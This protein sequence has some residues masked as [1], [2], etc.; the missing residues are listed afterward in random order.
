MAI[1]RLLDRPDP[2]AIERV[3]WLTRLR[4]IASHL[5]TTRRGSPSLDRAVHTSD[6]LVNDQD[7]D[8][9]LHDM[10]KI[11]WIILALWVVL[12][13]MQVFAAGGVGAWIEK[14]KT[15]TRI[16]IIWGGLFVG[17]LVIIWLR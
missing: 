2:S 16:Q 8:K 5:G 1:A 14:L 7:K 11:S 12:W 3:L 15:D 6:H 17:V 13:L 4:I 9:E 10:D